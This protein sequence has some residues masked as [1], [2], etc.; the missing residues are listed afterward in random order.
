MERGRGCCWVFAGGRA[1]FLV[2]VVVG[3]DA[4]NTGNNVASLQYN[5]GNGTGVAMPA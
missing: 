5:D 4:T 2:A 1:A 3:C